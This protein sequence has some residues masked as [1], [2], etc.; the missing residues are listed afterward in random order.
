V[1]VNE[2]FSTDWGGN[3]RASIYKNWR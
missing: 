1:F 2:K 3:E